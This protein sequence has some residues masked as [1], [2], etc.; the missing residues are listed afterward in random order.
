[1]WTTQ[2]VSTNAAAENNQ[3]I[4]INKDALSG[5]LKTGVKKSCSEAGSHLLDLLSVTTKKTEKTYADKK[6]TITK[7]KQKKKTRKNKLSQKNRKIH[8]T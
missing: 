7:K 4:E 1:M 2:R 5:I 3:T 6:D 8:Q